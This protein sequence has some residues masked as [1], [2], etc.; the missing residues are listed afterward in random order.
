MTNKGEKVYTIL[1]NNIRYQIR[2]PFNIRKFSG[3]IKVQKNDLLNIVEYKDGLKNGAK[4][5][6]Y[7]NGILKLKADFKNDKLNGKLI[8]WNSK[9]YKVIETNFI[10]DLENEVHLEWYGNGSPKARI[11]YKMGKK[12][13]E[14]IIWDKNTLPKKD[15]NLSNKVKIINFYNNK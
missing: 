4:R 2:F 14:Y 10:N 7:N 3:V 6:Y 1:E 15:W 9:G 11:M 5:V 13:G 12:N 8:G